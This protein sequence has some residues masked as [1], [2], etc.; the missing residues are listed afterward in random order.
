[1]SMVALLPLLLAFAFFVAAVFAVGTVLD[2]P[3]LTTMRET[4]GQPKWKWVPVLI[5]FSPVLSLVLNLRALFS[6]VFGFD[7]GRF[8]LISIFASSIFC[9]ALAACWLAMPGHPAPRNRVKIVFP[10][11]TLFWVLN[12]VMIVL[13]TRQ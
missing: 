2:L 1:M 13:F 8:F 9:A 12:L 3:A 4:M 6:R 7:P 5:A 10:L 11:A